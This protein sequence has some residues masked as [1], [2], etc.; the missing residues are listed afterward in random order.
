MKK[1]L[2]FIILLC[3]P[4]SIK[5]L[6]L[7]VDVTATGVALYDITN[8]QIIY[9]K[10]IDEQVELASLTKMYTEY[11]AIINNQNLNKKVKITNESF[12]GLEVY[13]KSGLK[14]GDVVTIRDLLYASN[15]PSGA[16]AAQALA[17]GTTKKVSEFIDLMNETVT[18]LGFTNTHLATTYGGSSKD[19]STPREIVMF[20]SLA[21]QNDTFRRVFG[22]DYYRLSNGLEA[23]NYTKAISNF[24]GYKYILTG[25]KSGFTDDA[26]MLLASTATINGIDY[27]LV[28]C[29][30]KV[31]HV[32]NE[33]YH[34]KD[35]YDIYDYV[36][37]RHYEKRNIISKGDYIDTIKVENATISEY[38]LNSDRELSLVLSDDEYA[39]LNYDYHIIDTI[40]S[41]TKKGSNIGH[42]DI[43]VGDELI[44][45]FK[46][47]L[48]DY[49]F[50]PTEEFVIKGSIYVLLFGVIIALFIFNLKKTK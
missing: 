23:I 16:D 2:F 11:T 22:A 8:N 25:N 12:R 49:I 40:S 6:E 35:S 19:V 46:L 28:V 38:I 13:T 39:N 1:I 48:Q 27:V 15:L 30:S 7:P 33:K 29:N 32:P 5:A 3:T 18:D 20:V 36:S 17:Y 26:G 21:I 37:K 34:I 9:G 43:Y 24:Y 50:S 44:Y 10:N 47:E 14:E 41:K 42:V 31:M 4:L 45:T